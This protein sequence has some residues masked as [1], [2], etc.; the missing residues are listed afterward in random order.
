MEFRL[1]PTGKFSGKF[2]ICHQKLVRAPFNAPAVGRK[3][4]G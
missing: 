4:A 1:T 2:L 3:F